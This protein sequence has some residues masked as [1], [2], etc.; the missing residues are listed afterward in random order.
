[1]V[2]LRFPGP[3]S[4]RGPGT[5]FWPEWEV[6]GRPV[7]PPCPFLLALDSSW[8]D[9]GGH[10]FKMAEFQGDPRVPKTLQP[11]SQGTHD[12]LT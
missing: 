10:M 11:T 7:H 9:L 4:F 2:R 5:E 8:G 12:G 3:L 6:S 1:M